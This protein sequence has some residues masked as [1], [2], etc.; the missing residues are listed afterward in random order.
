MSKRKNSKGF[1]LS[2]DSGPSAR[3]RSPEKVSMDQMNRPKVFRS[4]KRALE[5]Q[6]AD[7]QIKDYMRGLD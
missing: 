6:D 2:F 7:N 5:A 4:R 3:K 1:T